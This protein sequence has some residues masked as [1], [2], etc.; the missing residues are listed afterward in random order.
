M[1]LEILINGQWVQKQRNENLDQLTQVA[2]AV[3]LAKPEY[4]VRV[5]NDNGEVLW[6][7][8]VNQK[9]NDLKDIPSIDDILDEIT[10]PEQIQAE[11]ME[12]SSAT[13][14]DDVEPEAEEMSDE[15]FKEIQ[16]EAK[17]DPT[18]PVVN[19]KEAAEIMKKAKAPKEEP[20]PEPKE[21]ESK[22]EE[23]KSSH[24][25]SAEF[26]DR[27]KKLIRNTTDTFRNNLNKLVEEFLKE[28][29]GE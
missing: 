29:K 4:S 15:E 9:E 12:I 1:T 14:F 11:E 5:L 27:L 22:P 2:E 25:D 28:L 16:D 6:L 23:V 3:K 18:G 13:L 10:N 24:T 21:E 8:G 19:T 7:D 17:K 26:N 20:Q